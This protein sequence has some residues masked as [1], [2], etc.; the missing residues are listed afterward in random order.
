MSLKR[1]HYESA[2][3]AWRGLAV[4]PSDPAEVT[5]DCT[6]LAESLVLAGELKNRMGDAISALTYLEKAL[7][8]A[9]NVLFGRQTS[10]EECGQMADKVASYPNAKALEVLSHAALLRLLSSI[11]LKTTKGLRHWRWKQNG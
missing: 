1:S 6:S 3:T 4:S 2:V 5:T 9:S 11:L 10:D 7:K 8:I